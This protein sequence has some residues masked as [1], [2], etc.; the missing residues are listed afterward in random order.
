MVKITDDK[1]KK[2]L[3]R[4]R[5][6]LKQKHEVAYLKKSAKRIIKLIDSEREYSKRVES[7]VL[8][9]LNHCIFITPKS[10]RGTDFV[11]KKIRYETIRRIAKALLKCL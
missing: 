7:G 10:K 6:S 8:F 11:A 1:K 3:D 2:K 4:K 5:I 9:S